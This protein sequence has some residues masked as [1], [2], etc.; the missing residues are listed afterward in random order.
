LEQLSERDPP[1]LQVCFVIA[2]II[3]GLFAVFCVV[4]SFYVAETKYSDF[5]RK[6]IVSAWILG[7]PLYFANEWGLLRKFGRQMGDKRFER[8]KHTTSLVTKL[9]LA[10][11]TVVVGLY[12]GDELLKHFAPGN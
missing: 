2:S 10:I 12:Y 8:H 9:W 1:A 7:P 4:F 5:W 11:G 3:G 6:V